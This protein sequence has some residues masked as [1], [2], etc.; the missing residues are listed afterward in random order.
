MN[1]EK[2]AHFFSFS[3]QIVVSLPFHAFAELQKHCQLAAKLN[4]ASH[5]ASSCRSSA[6]GLLLLYVAA[7]IAIVPLQT[8]I[9]ILG[10]NRVEN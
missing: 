8:T 4:D 7:G 10:E 3:T 6:V 1:E 2:M 5:C 9:L